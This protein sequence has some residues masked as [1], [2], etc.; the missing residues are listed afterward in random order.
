M[1]KYNEV[2]YDTN[3]MHAINMFRRIIFFIFY[4]SENYMISIM[5]S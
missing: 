3:L 5:N 2:G 4:E 1:P